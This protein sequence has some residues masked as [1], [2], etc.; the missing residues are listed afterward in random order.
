[1][2]PDSLFFPSAVISPGSLLHVD[3]FHLM[4]QKIPIYMRWP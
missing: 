4:L 2:A 3:F 1:M